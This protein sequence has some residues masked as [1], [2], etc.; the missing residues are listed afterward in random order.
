MVAVGDAAWVSTDKAL[1]KVVGL[2]ADLFEPAIMPIPWGHMPPIPRGWW[3]GTGGLAVDVDGWVWVN[4]GGLCLFEVEQASRGEV[5]Y[6]LALYPVDLSASARRSGVWVLTSKL[7]GT[8]ATVVHLKL[9]GPLAQK[10][11]PAG[12][13]RLPEEYVPIRPPS[14][15]ALDGGPDLTLSAPLAAVH[16]ATD[17]S[18]RVW[19]A[20]QGDAGTVLLV[21][22]ESGTCEQKTAFGQLVGKTPVTDIAVAEGG[23]V[24]FATDGLGVVVFDGNE[25]RLHAM[26]EHLPVLRGTDRKPVNYVLP[27]R[28]GRVAVC[29]GEYL[30]IW[31]PE[32]QP[33]QR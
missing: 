4:G 20:G 27:L 23:K 31:S 19:I 5:A 25:F 26:N 32:D 15:E 12:K 2:L 9:S 22:D 3:H 16:M 30:L 33:K 6:S 1:L 29:T 7:Q 21:C 18:G 13:Q 24:Y 17:S 28:D 10:Q 14:S 11:D 8:R